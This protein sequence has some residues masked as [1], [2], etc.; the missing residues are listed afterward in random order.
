MSRGKE[1]PPLKPKHVSQYRKERLCRGEW[2]AARSR[3]GL[4]GTLVHLGGLGSLGDARRVRCR[5]G[6]VR[7]TSPSPA[8]L[9]A[10]RSD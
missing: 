8:F 10:V 1:A 3:P 2:T 9:P 6:W 5:N 4:A 7:M